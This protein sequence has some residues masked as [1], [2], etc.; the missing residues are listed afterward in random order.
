LITFVHQPEYLPWIGFFDKLARSDVFV[1]YDDAQFEHGGFQNRNKIR[2]NTGWRWLTVPIIHNNPQKIKDVKIAASN[3]RK[4]HL[5][6]IEQHYNQTPYFEEYY[7]QLKEA[8]LFNHE[9]LI[10]L[11]LHLINLFSDFL[12]IEPKI[13]RSSEFPYCGEDRNEKLVSMC[14]FMGSDTYLSGYGARAYMDEALFF[15]SKIKLVWHNYVHPTYQQKYVGFEPFMSVVDLLFNMGPEA[16]K[17]LLDG[18]NKNSL[19][20]I[21]STVAGVLE[22]SVIMPNLK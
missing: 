8:L 14:K 1:V 6:I 16:K 12:G 22:T 11:N 18:G 17:I 9:L 2:T 19:P 3:W 10:G 5:R 7:P 20:P 13:V 4:E 15:G 21:K